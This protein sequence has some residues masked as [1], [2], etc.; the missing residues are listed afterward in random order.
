M[1]THDDAG[2]ERRM[3]K[4][5]TGIQKNKDEVTNMMLAPLKSF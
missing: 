5:N 1:I 4:T 2:R 3:T